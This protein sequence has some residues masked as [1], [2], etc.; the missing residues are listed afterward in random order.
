MWFSV[1]NGEGVRPADVDT[2]SSKAYVYIRRNIVLVDG[3]DD[4]P[5][6]YRW[7]ECRIPRDAMAIWQKAMEQDAAL[8]DVYAALTELAEMIL[9]EG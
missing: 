4:A 2:T 5:A 3:T 7:E 1:A 8:D 9:E 6:H